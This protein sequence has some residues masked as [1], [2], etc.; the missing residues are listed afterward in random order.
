MTASHEQEQRLAVLHLCRLF[1]DWRSSVGMKVDT[2]IWST[3]IGIEVMRYFG[4]PATA[5][6][7]SV[8]VHNPRMVEL[9][10]Q[11]VEPTVENMDE[12]GAWALGTDPDKPMPETGRRGWNCHLIMHVERFGVLVD[13]SLEQYNRPAKNIVLEPLPALIDPVF[14]EGQHVAVLVRGCH[15]LYCHRPEQQSYRD[16]YDWHEGKQNSD[17]G[18]LIRMVRS[19]IEAQLLREHGDVAYGG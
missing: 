16:T 6:P 18:G 12:V 14:W 9:H 17:I 19:S 5:L 4:L 15:V 10:S 2:C 1:P 8:Q 13:L 11:G 3:R 7:V